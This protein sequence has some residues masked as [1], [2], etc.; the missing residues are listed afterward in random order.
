[1]RLRIST[2]DRR[3]PA[4]LISLVDAAGDTVICFHRSVSAAARHG[5]LLQQL[6][7]LADRESA[8]WLN[9]LAADAAEKLYGTRALGEL[10]GI[11]Q[12]KKVVAA[13]REELHYRERLRNQQPD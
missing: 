7:P 13:V 11:H 10:T 5:E 9:G 1:M 12:A 6:A 4:G 2:R 3:A 8:E